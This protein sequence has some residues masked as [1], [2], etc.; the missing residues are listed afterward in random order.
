MRG[1][2]GMH[3]PSNERAVAQR[4]ELPVTPVREPARFARANVLRT[5]VRIGAL[6]GACAFLLVRLWP[7]VESKPLYEDEA[8][9]GLIS[10]RPLP[11]VL[12]TVVV[13]RGGA[14]L[15]SVLAHLAFAIDAS[16]EA[17]RW[18]SVLCALGAVPLTFD[19]GRRLAGTPAGIVAAVVVASSTALSVY[20]TFGRMYALFVLVAVLFAD[21][22]VRA[23]ER[24]TLGAVAAA[25]AAGV[26]LPAVHPYGAIPAFVALVAATI[27]WRRR[28]RRGAPTRLRRPPP[29]RPG[30]GRHRRL[31]PARHSGRG[32]ERARRGPDGLRRR[33]PPAR[34]VLS[35]RSP[36]EG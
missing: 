14:P 16:P 2:S 29:G 9:S 6:A 34:P 8:I 31:P 19:L 35:P 7:D 10:M 15:H 30:R 21:L 27:L 17:L 1:A 32:V 28:D 20:G 26:L 33:G 24:R 11:E 22:Y 23:L 4:P 25:A 36:R 12:D 3:E 18:L 5:F 13:D